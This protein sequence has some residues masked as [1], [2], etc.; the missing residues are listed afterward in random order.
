[1]ADFK[2]FQNPI[3]KKWIVFAPRRAKRP[4][5]AKGIEPVCPFCPGRESNE[6]EIYRVPVISSRF[7]VIGNQLVGSQSTSFQT[8][9]LKTDQPETDNRQL[10]TDNRDWLVRVLNNKF[11]FSDIHEIII[12]SP[13]HNKNFDKLS[14][15]QVELILKTYKNRYLAHQAK[16]QV[17]IFHNR[18]EAGGESLPHPHTQ[19]AVIPFEVKTDL[20]ML[21]PQASVGLGPK[22]LT[23][24]QHEQIMEEQEMIETPY[25]YMFCPITSGWPDEIWVS[26]KSRGRLFGE[27]TDGEIA[28]LSYTL[29]R[30]IRIFDLRHANTFPFNMYIYPGGD[31]Y[32]RIIPR[33]KSLGGFEL[34][35]GILVNTQDPRETIKFIS[36]HFPKPN[37]AKILREHQAD[38]KRHA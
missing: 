38:Y 21:D 5:V 32:L 37:E 11:P 31:W 6:E 23:I 25:F 13:D 16:G 20:P 30:L 2:Y 9:E 18:G 34:G 3:S 33:L 35:T 8:D 4:D 10:K 22:A 19:L 17:Y 24:N 27:I 1:M 7:S 14:L 26:P 15:H 28:D 29:Q 12:H 36:E